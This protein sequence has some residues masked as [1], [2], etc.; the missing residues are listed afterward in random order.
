[1][2]PKEEAVKQMPVW[3]SDAWR[4]EYGAMADLLLQQWWVQAAEGKR[5]LSG[6]VSQH[7]CLGAGWKG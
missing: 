7:L 3:E 2:A 6:A 1:V 4:A 5:N